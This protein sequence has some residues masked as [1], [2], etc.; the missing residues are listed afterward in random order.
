[1]SKFQSKFKALEQKVRNPDS[2]TIPKCCNYN[3]NFLYSRVL[4]QRSLNLL[5]Y[6][7]TSKKEQDFEIEFVIFTETLSFCV[8][9]LSSFS[10]FGK[11]SIASFLKAQFYVCVF[12]SLDRKFQVDS[13]NDKSIFLLL[14]MCH[15]V[16]GIFSKEIFGTKKKGSLCLKLCYIRK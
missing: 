4:L 7:R 6:R 14:L 5:G 15:F 8:L 10:G 13:K 2:C 16:S 9:V 11:I 3:P 1:M 12:C